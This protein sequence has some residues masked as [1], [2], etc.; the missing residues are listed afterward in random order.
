MVPASF[1]KP[2]RF[3][4][5]CAKLAGATFLGWLLRTSVADHGAVIRAYNQSLYEVPRAP[6]LLSAKQLKLL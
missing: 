4:R 3:A 1:L 2:P 5:S 6:R